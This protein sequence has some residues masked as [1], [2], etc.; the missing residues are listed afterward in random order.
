MDGKGIF[1]PHTSHVGTEKY[2][3]NRGHAEVLQL[4]ATKNFRYCSAS[5]FIH[6]PNRLKD[7]SLTTKFQ[8]L[9][10]AN[11]FHYRFVHSGVRK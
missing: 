4:I 11:H 6:F 10:L 9:C 1:N 8:V 3:T 2:R 5:Q 7:Q